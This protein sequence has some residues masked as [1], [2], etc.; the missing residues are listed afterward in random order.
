MDG[1][2]LNFVKIGRD[3]ND[4]VF[5][6]AFG[7]VCGLL[8]A[9]WKVISSIA[10]VL[11]IVLSL[12]INLIVEIF[13]LLP[14]VISFILNTCAAFLR[15]ILA[16]SAFFGRHI[17]TLKVA[18]TA[19]ASLLADIISQIEAW[20]LD[21]THFLHWV[22]DGLQTCLESTATS[23]VDL[24]ALLAGLR[25][26]TWSLVVATLRL[27]LST[28]I[29]LVTLPFRLL[30]ALPILFYV[31]LIGIPLAY[32]LAKVTW[33]WMQ[34]QNHI[35]RTDT[36]CA[37]AYLKTVVESRLIDPLHSRLL[38]YVDFMHSQILSPV[39]VWTFF[40]SQLMV[41]QVYL[42]FLR[43]SSFIIRRISSIY[44]STLSTAARILRSFLVTLFS[45]WLSTCCHF[46]SLWLSTC[47]HFYYW[48]IGVFGR[49]ANAMRLVSIWIHRRFSFYL[50]LIH[51]NITRI[52][53][54]FWHD[55]T[56]YL[57]SI[58]ALVCVLLSS[59][60]PNQRILN[61]GGDSTGSSG[62]N[63]GDGDTSGSLSSSH[64]GLSSSTVL[65]DL[66]RELTESQE[67][68]KCVVCLEGVKSMVI[69]PCRHACLCRPCAVRI[70]NHENVNQRLCPLCRSLMHEV[71][72]I[73]M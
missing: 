25:L 32:R 26:T 11:V 6:F 5:G 54:D 41:D 24:A 65:K 64:I 29:F 46:F 34:T 70:I 31:I 19:F 49:A 40:A 18:L 43:D 33:A 47:C 35:T 50:I 3:W 57:N 44:I 20:F 55:L 42:P 13:A 52:L 8:K 61:A 66:R 48:I 63:D 17:Q 67:R 51:G 30:A 9:V 28:L 72:H 2:F 58:L 14:Q 60:R 38:I 62:G 22:L 53:G 39:T 59:L 73:Y 69:L 12:F 36:Y 7:S 21:G 45:L 16:V 37:V 23:F 1:K 10:T 4:Y 27:L 56:S 68:Q 15:F 71:L